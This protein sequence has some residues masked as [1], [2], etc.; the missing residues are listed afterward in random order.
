M[1]DDMVD[2]MFP[3]LIQVLTDAGVQSVLT[4]A[5]KRAIL[6]AVD[7]HVEEIDEN[8]FRIGMLF[9]VLDVDT[10]DPEHP[11]MSLTMD[12]SKLAGLA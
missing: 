12:L 3:S 10:T 4:Q 11:Q 8:R 7:T 5:Q 9:V 1:R 2:V 6:E